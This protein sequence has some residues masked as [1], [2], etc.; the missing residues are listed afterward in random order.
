MKEWGKEVAMSESDSR[1]A[2]LA[3]WQ[4]SDL[5]VWPSAQVLEAYEAFKAII[6]LVIPSDAAR[7]RKYW[8][9]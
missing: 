9:S 2:A 5:P 6:R 4:S 8:L 3:L 7:S 1:Q